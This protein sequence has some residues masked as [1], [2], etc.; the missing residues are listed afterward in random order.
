MQEAVLRLLLR[1][2]PNAQPADA[3]RLG[4][5]IVRRCRID[6]LRRRSPDLL[7]DAAGDLA[8]EPA[9]PADGLDQD[10]SWQSD[11][12]LTRRLGSAAVRLLELIVTG[13]RSNKALAR[14][15][16]T[17]PC[18]VRRRRLRIQRLLEAIVAGDGAKENR[19]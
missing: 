8:V 6:R 17:S 15:L 14:I 3:V 10:D 19:G 11:V 18:A 7:G 12:E 1:L 5:F 13:V 16:D 4:H 2:G 9:S